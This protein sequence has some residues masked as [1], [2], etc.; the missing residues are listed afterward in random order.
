MIQTV[1]S[2]PRTRTK[3]AY[4][5]GAFENLNDLFR[6]HLRTTPIVCT[7]SDREVDRERPQCIQA[8]DD[9]ALVVFY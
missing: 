2:K 1:L 5:V 6:H 8:S 4:S 7:M 3:Y 9:I